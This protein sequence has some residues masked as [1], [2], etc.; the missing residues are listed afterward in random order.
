ME[1]KLKLMQVETQKDTASRV[2][3]PETLA[4]LLVQGLHSQDKS[5]ITVSDKRGK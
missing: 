1:E 3:P 2:K 5:I 4:I